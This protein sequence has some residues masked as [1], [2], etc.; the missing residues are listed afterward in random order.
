LREWSGFKQD[1]DGKFMVPD[2]SPKDF[3]LVRAVLAAAPASADGGELPPAALA[4]EVAG[5]V[6]VY[7]VDQMRERD[8]MWQARV[9]A[10]QASGAALPKVDERAAFEA[11][12]RSFGKDDHDLQRS[13]GY[14]TTITGND[15]SWGDIEGAWKA[16][17]ARAAL[18]ASAEK[19]S[20][21]GAEK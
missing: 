17:Q 16:W 7:T 9:A 13:A 4:V 15:Y 11:W 20:I 19:N 14:A 12:C 21:G 8:A 3:A 5:H 6:A 18:S 10:L 1:A 2:L